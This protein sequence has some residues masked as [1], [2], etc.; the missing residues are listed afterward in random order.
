MGSMDTVVF[1]DAHG[2]TGTIYEMKA[3][4]DIFDARALGTIALPTNKY[5][6]RDF[7]Q[8]DS[9]TMLFRHKVRSGL[10]PRACCLVRT[11]SNYA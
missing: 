1:I 2:L 9:L 3:T 5:E 7:L 6:L 8:G 10:L 11:H 4:E